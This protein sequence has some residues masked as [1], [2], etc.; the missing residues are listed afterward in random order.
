M[1]ARRGGSG[2]RDGGRHGYGTIAVD[3][4]VH[5]ACV[6]ISFLCVLSGTP[7]LTPRREGLVGR[8]ADIKIVGQI[9]RNSVGGE[10]NKKAGED[11]FASTY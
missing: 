3:N 6:R 1:E 4:F 8:R 10:F 5:L 2:G 11:S 9:R 7:R